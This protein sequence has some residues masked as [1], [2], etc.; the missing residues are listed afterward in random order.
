MYQSVEQ[1]F[2]NLKLNSVYYLPN[3]G[4]VFGNK[5]I[6]FLKEF[7]F[8]REGVVLNLLEAYD[9]IQSNKSRL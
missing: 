7:D 9:N 2:L 5:R 3:G 6:E 8:V 4:C 1:A